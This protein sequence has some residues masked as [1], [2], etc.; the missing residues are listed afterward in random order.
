MSLLRYRSVL[1]S[2]L[3]NSA[4]VLSNFVSAEYDLVLLVSKVHFMRR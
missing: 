3:A 4:D 2:S 1:L